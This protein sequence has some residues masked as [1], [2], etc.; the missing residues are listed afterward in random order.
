[1]QARHFWRR[2][3]GLA[4]WRKP[5]TRPGLESSSPCTLQAERS[6]INTLQCTRES[7]FKTLLVICVAWPLIAGR[8][9]P[10]ET[11]HVAAVT[12]LALAALHLEMA[13]SRESRFALLATMGDDR[14]LSFMLKNLLGIRAPDS[15]G[16]LFAT[17]VFQGDQIR[18][19]PFPRPVPPI[20]FLRPSL[21]TWLRQRQQSE[22]RSRIQ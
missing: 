19:P 7:R 17:R 8:T 22:D 11:L 15:I 2:R 1:M 20:T 4:V 5:A 14:H 6:Q 12:S 13:I 10:H 18:F 21:E 9:Q 16:S 3:L